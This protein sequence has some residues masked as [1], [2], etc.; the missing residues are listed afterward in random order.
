MLAKCSLPPVTR[1]LT[2]TLPPSLIT[3][4]GIKVSKLNLRLSPT[5]DLLGLGF[6]TI[7]RLITGMTVISNDLGFNSRILC[8]APPFH[9]VKRIPPGFGPGVCDAR[10]GL[11]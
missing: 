1:P 5:Q 7:T 3:I 9:M 4:T 6:S 10:L 2:T 11:V 8:T